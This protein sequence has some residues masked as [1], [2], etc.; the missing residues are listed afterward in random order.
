MKKGLS[1]QPDQL[2]LLDDSEISEKMNVNHFICTGEDYK[3]ISSSEII[4]L[5]PY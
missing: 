3:I 4:E 5:G 2:R 1:F